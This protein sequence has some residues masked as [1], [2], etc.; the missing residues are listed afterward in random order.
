M[1]SFSLFL[2]KSAKTKGK[3]ILVDS[4]IQPKVLPLNICMRLYEIDGRYKAFEVSVSVPGIG[5]FRTLIPWRTLPFDF[6][7]VPWLRGVS[8]VRKS[9]VHLGHDG[10][11]I[12]IPADGGAVQFSRLRG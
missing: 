6:I 7:E 4:R 1:F 11:L 2:P 5:N 3:A 9:G 12:T 8:E 10:M